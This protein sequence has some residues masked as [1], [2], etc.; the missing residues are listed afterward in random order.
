MTLYPGEVLTSFLQGQTA[1]TR[2]EGSLLAKDY[3][4]YQQGRLLA[5]LEP[6]RPGRPPRLI[7]TSP[8]EAEAVHAVREAFLQAYPNG[9]VFTEQQVARQTAAA[10][11]D[12]G[13][14]DI[15][16]QGRSKGR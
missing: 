6:A 13:G 8:E 1:P 11:Q 16:Q 3:H 10:A 15:E 9:E 14:I 12:N 5:Q 2:A 4:L 7:L